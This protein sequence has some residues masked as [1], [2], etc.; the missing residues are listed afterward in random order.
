MEHGADSMF[1]CLSCSV[2]LVTITLLPLCFVRL[3]DYIFFSC[4]WLSAQL[5]RVLDAG[6]GKS[7]LSAVQLH[8]LVINQVNGIHSIGA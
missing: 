5:W 1:V 7:D 6:D 4:S 3:H 2:D 8:V